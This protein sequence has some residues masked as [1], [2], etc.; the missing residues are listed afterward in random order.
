VSG[1][2]DRTNSYLGSAAALLF[3]L[4]CSSSFASNVIKSDS[5]EIT[6]PPATNS[7]PAPRLTLRTTDH[8][9]TDS[10]ADMKDPASDPAAEKV[11]SPALAEAADSN[12]DEGA[13]NATTDTDTTV[14][15]DELPETALRLPGVADKDLPRFRRQMY[16]T[17][18]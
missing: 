1:K 6:D 3:C 11:S 12:A 16:R 9:L 4:S 10:V 8:G 17:D 14:A 13:E 15:I 2:T 18:I 7:S 5:D